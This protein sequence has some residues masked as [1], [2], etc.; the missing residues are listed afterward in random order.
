MPPSQSV[1]PPNAGST[2][3]PQ[4][5]QMKPG[6]TFGIVFAIVMFVILIVGFRIVARWGHG[7]CKTATQVDKVASVERQGSVGTRAMVSVSKTDS[8]ETLVG[9]NGKPVVLPQIPP[10]A[11]F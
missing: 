4:S 8:A 10:Q 2:A 7:T 6:T 11:H 1:V 3:P 5:G 9:K